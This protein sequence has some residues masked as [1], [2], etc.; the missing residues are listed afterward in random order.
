MAPKPST[1]NARAMAAKSGAGSS[2]RM[3]IPLFS[4]GRWRHFAIRS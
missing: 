2:M 1:L 4:T 3:P